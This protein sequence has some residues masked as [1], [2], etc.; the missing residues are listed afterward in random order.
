M[1]RRPAIWLFLAVVAGI[2]LPGCYERKQTAILN[3]D[4]SGKMLIETDVA[5]PSNDVPGKEK[6]TAVSFGRQLIADFINN[7]QGVAAWSDVAVTELADGRA[8]IAAVAYFPDISLLHFDLPLTFT[9]KKQDDGTYLFGVE[10]TRSAPTAPVAMTDDQV[11]EQV[12][13]AQ[14]QYK[15]QQLAMQTAL[16]AFNLQM[17][18]TLPGEITQSHIFTKQDRN[19]SLTLDGKKIA[20]ALDKFMTD[21]AALT[22]TIRSGKDLIENDDILLNAMYGEKGPVA[23]V[24][25]VPADALSAFDY[26]GESLRAAAVQH[27]MLEDAGVQILPKF[28]VKPPAT[29]PAAG[30]TA[31]PAPGAR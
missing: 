14:A 27:D 17:T 8:H 16:T 30:P 21:D 18:F 13:K 7:S 31:A 1:N 26:R 6:P 5:V 23:A 24:V 20:G 28:I 25:K 19:V 29:A 11:R 3:P 4:G 10:R 12:S 2:L 22:A 15:E 9:W